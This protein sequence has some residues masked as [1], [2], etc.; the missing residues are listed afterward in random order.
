MKVS[1][2]ISMLLMSFFSFSQDFI[3]FDI[4]KKFE[5]ISYETV[6]SEVLQSNFDVL[7]ENPYSELKYLLENKATFHLIDIDG[8]QV[9]EVVY[10]GWN[11]GEGEMVV[12]Y[13]LIKDQLVFVQNFLGRIVDIRSNESNQTRFLVYDYA[14]CAGYVDHLQTFDFNPK[15]KMFEIVKSIAK[16]NETEIPDN[17]IDTFRIKITKSPYNLRY[18]PEI[19]TGIANSFGYFEPIKQENIAATYQAGDKGTVYAQ[20]ID[21]TGRIWWFV[22]MDAMPRSGENLF[23]EGNNLFV[24]YQPIGWISSKYVEKL[25]QDQ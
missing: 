12:V 23:Y 13:R 15:T 22:L 7:A 3:Y 2:Q 21:D 11:G 16:I 19:K 17:W 14:C 18:S 4:A 25:N 5:W 1:I 9:R 20:A 6:S 10:N 8:D 24:N